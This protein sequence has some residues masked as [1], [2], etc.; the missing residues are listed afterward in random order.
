MADKERITKTIFKAVDEVNK[1]SQKGSRLDKTTE[2]V[3]VGEKG[4]L[5]SLGI[6]NFITAVERKIE[7]EFGV[8]ITL[9]DER[10]MSQQANPFETI[11]KLINY[12]SSLL[13]KDEAGEE[14][15]G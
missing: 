2:A 10:A 15:N 11:G 1:M 5:D 14:I 12:I 6:I 7:E 13:E 3:L 4:K 8:I 9:A